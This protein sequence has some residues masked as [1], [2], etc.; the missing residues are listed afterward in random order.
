MKPKPFTLGRLLGIRR[1]RQR[2]RQGD[3]SA[4]SRAVRRQE[5]VVERAVD[6]QVAARGTLRALLGFRPLA[7]IG[8]PV[9]V[10]EVKQYRAYL[11]AL[12]QQ[13]G[14]AAARLPALRETETAR[15]AELAEAQRA[16]KVLENLRNRRRDA[17]RH[18]ARRREQKNLDEI[19]ARIPGTGNRR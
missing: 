10:T 6:R 17:L 19:A 18:W 14:E 4:A 11:S 2:R 16:V 13:A 5:T 12:A 7:A 9:P 1:L 8:R 3:L 15:R